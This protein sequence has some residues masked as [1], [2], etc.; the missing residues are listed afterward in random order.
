MTEGLQYQLTELTIQ[1]LQQ[2]QEAGCL[3]LEPGFQRNSVWHLSD[4]RKLIQSILE[5]YPVPSIFL[6][7]RDE[8]GSLV[9]DV[10]D[11]KQRLETIFIFMGTKGFRGERFDLKFRFPEDD[12]AYWYEWKDLQKWK[13]A[14]QF[15]GYQI[16]VVNVSGSL[17]D[18][19]DLFVR[20]N[21]TGKALTSSE[22]R[23]AH[24]YQS[25]FLKQAHRLARRCRP[26]FE[27]SDLLSQTQFDRMKDVELVSELVASIAQG[28][29]IDS[30]AAIDRTIG[31]EAMHAATLGRAG[32]Q[33]THVI[34]LIRRLFP[35]LRETRFSKVSEFYSLF[36]L[37]WEL[38][39]R[40]LVLRGSDRT[41]VADGLLKAFS[42]G[43]DFV[44]EQQRLGKPI[45]P[46]Y[47]T[48]LS[49]LPSVQQSTDKL[50]QRSRRAEIL[51]G[52]FGGLFESKD[53]RRLFTPEQRRILWHSHDS[54]R[55]HVCKVPLDWTNFEVDHLLA[56]S[57]GGSTT[58][59]NADLICKSCNA[60]KGAHRRARRRSVAR[61]ARRAASRQ[62]AAR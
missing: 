2:L 21:S 23:H 8:H 38:D 19:V 17:S 52:V 28:G 29:P 31:N 35:S 20:I 51:R 58:L 25:D 50:S 59:D 53:D 1:A 34:G 7:K 55:C 26:F 6:Y 4:R 11:G 32:K 13:L 14:T 60:S 56:H 46:G 16:Q 44:R 15:L 42:A 37:V 18:I 27:R 24:Y 36:M 33:L 10:I 54:K 9:Y 62:R 61:P 43:V 22:K 49:Y 45:P 5:N 3:N 30:K 57:R 41:G 12:Q 40:K 47:E 39:K 48:H